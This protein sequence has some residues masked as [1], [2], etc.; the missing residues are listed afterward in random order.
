MTDACTNN[1]PAPVGDSVIIAELAAMPKADLRNLVDARIWF[2]DDAPPEIRRAFH[3]R[4]RIAQ[5][6]LDDESRPS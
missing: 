4:Q 3:A 1:V 6:I 5:G 2:R